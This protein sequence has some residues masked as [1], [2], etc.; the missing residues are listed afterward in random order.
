MGGCS[1][2]PLKRAVERIPWRVRGAFEVPD[3]LRYPL[4]PALLQEIDSSNFGRADRDRARV[5]LTEHERVCVPKIVPSGRLDA[6]S[7]K[8]G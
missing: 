8:L 4:R 6:L 1:G 3:V 2:S 7:C 5:V